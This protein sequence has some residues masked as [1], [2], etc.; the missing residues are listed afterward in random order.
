MPSD[1]S[2]SQSG[3]S[4]RAFQNIYEQQYNVSSF[5]SPSGSA[6]SSGS[7]DSSVNIGPFT[8]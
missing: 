8:R 2:S 3:D 4:F 6:S 7:Q 5:S 1:N